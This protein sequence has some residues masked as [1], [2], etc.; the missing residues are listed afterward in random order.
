MMGTKGMELINQERKKQV[1]MGYDMAHDH[2]HD[3][4]E[5]V[6]AAMFALT[7][8]GKYSQDGFTIFE[9]HVREDR[10]TIENLVKAGA[11]IAAEI[12]RILETYK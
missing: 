3:Y 7:E 11:L 8:D 12:D 9:E 4:G 10:H 5:L 6:K 1:E 2:Q